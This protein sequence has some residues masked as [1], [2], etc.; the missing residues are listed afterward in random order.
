LDTTSPSHHVNRG[1]IAGGVVGGLAVAVAVIAVFIFFRCRQSPR[2][3]VTRSS[4]WGG[5]MSAESQNTS[6]KPRKSGLRRGMDNDPFRSIPASRRQSQ[7]DSVGPLNLNPGPFS[8][9]GTFDED[10]TSLS[11]EKV[12]APTVPE[13][14]SGIRSSV[15]TVE[16]MPPLPNNRDNRRSSASVKYADNANYS[17]PRRTKSY[18]NSTNDSRVMNRRNSV[19]GHHG[20]PPPT[21]GEG[22]MIPMS[23]SASGSV[24]R[25]PRKPVPVY[26][27]FDLPPTIYNEHPNGNTDESSSDHHS[28]GHNFNSNISLSSQHSVAQM[29]LVH[30]ASFGEM[31]PNRPMH[32]LIPDMPPAS[33]H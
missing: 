13:M 2:G 26:D 22:E 1:A 33:K 25:T 21:S 19:D 9:T 12:I 11:L 28:H 23:R 29:V 20:H 6:T 3:V 14:F 7:A 31:D 4:G 17:R 10:V 5:L 27:P 15:G 24:R 16:G 8:S 32:Y 30:K 18:G